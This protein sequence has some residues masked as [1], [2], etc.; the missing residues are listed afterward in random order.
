MLLDFMHRNLVAGQEAHRVRFRYA[1]TWLG[2]ALLAAHE[3]NLMRAHRA[4][5]RHF[6]PQ[7]RL[8]CCCGDGR[9]ACVH[10]V[11]FIGRKSGTL[12]S[13]QQ[14]YNDV[15]G[16]YRARVQQLFCHLGHWGLVRKM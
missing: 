7:G 15:H 13:R 2:H 11:P 4:A 3:G 10:I 1:P 14:F 16:W 9:N 5:F 8:L 6:V 12:T